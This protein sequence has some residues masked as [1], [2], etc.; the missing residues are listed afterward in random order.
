MDM[1]LDDIIKKD[2]IR[3]GPGRGR[4]RGRARG[5]GGRGGGV[6]RAGRTIQ[7]TRQTPYSR[8]STNAQLSPC[9]ETVFGV[10]NLA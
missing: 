8:V 6:Q 7:K 3:A 10:Y 2:R 9:L 5:S 1:S 4:G